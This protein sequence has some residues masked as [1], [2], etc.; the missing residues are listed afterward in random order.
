MAEGQETAAARGS[1]RTEGKRSPT[2]L[3][4]ANRVPKAANMA[5]AFASKQIAL[6]LRIS[7]QSHEHPGEGSACC[8]YGCPAWCPRIGAQVLGMASGSRGERLRFPLGWVGVAPWREGSRAALLSSGVLQ[9]LSRR[10]Q[11][12]LAAEIPRY[13][14]WHHWA[15]AGQS[16]MCVVGPSAA[17][18]GLVVR[19][20]RG[21]VLGTAGGASRPFTCP[22]PSPPGDPRAPLSPF[23]AT[24]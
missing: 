15:T 21:A 12:P 24:L 2:A 5:T 8:P 6:C 7:R 18:L 10:G 11:T 16:H 23:P 13:G 4:E 19:W 22:V 20:V 1:G 14:K 17:Q 9:L 3:P